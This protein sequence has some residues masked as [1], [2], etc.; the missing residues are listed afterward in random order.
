VEKGQAP[1]PFDP[2]EAE[3]VAEAVATLG[4]R[5]VVLTAVA[6]DDRVRSAHR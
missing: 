5:Y 2:E 3:R 1:A 6:R 4:L